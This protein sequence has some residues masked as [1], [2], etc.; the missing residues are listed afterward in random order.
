MGTDGGDGYSLNQ[1]VP[2]K[3]EISPF[4][5]WCRIYGNKELALLV[6]YIKKKKFYHNY[7]V[8]KLPCSA[9]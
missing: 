8:L 7:F 3:T 4:N 5:D 1:H 9:A 6:G 2:G